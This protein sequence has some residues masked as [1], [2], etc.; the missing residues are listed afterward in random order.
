MI[1]EGFKIIDVNELLQQYLTDFQVV[2]QF[3]TTR[4]WKLE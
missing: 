4:F 2:E 1:I 3:L